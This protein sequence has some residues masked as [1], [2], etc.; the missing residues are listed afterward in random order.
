MVVQGWGSQGRNNILWKLSAP[1]ATIK[2]SDTVKEGWFI[3]S[4]VRIPQQHK[5]IS[6][7]SLSM[8]FRGEILPFFGVTLPKVIDA[9][10]TQAPLIEVKDR[11]MDV[12]L[13]LEDNTLLHME[14][15]SSEPTVDDQIRYAYYD[16]KLFSERKQAIRRMVIYAAGVQK[17]PEPL[18]I[19]SLL[20]QQQVIH[21]SRHFDGHRE[22]EGILTKIQQRR[23]L[24]AQDKLRI[25]LLPMM[26]EQP[27]DRSRAA[28]AVT[29]A[30][31]GEKT[32][33]SAYL[34]GTMY[35]ANF[36]NIVEPEKSKILEVLNMSQAF[37][38]LYR[39]HEEIGIEKG[40]K[41]G[42]MQGI[43]KTA[44]TA[45]KEGFPLETIAKLTGLPYER[46][47]ELQ[48]QLKLP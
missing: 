8:T 26:F 33:N 21:L 47:V 20:T 23:P 22:L 32:D 9:V 35:A 45:L 43:E 15:E 6:L 27:R 18:D 44:I 1:Y 7:R 17:T 10:S 30:L 34:I 38:E 42:I 39:R 4:D 41:Q 3:D 28:W 36:S 37:Q 40:I 48:R 2:A 16:L 11:D 46:I 29:E 19:G 5:D 24:D 14:F 25:M 12:V 31:D 13:A